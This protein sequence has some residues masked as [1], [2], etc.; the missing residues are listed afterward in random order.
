MLVDPPTH[1]EDKIEN[2]C[3][4]SV[5]NLD[6]N[7]MNTIIKPTMILAV[8]AKN[9]PINFGPN[10]NTSLISF[11]NSNKNNI[12]GS[13]KYFNCPIKLD[14]CGVNSQM[15]IVAPIIPPK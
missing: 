2:V 6:F 14:N 8:T 11:F 4:A 9:E 15:C 3:H 12:I 13:K 1:E 10:L 7:A 5:S